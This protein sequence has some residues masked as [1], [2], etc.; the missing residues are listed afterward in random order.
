MQSPAIAELASLARVD[1]PP[2]GT[3]EPGSSSIERMQRQFARATM[4]AQC[5]ISSFDG[6]DTHRDPRADAGCFTLEHR[7]TL[8]WRAILFGDRNAQFLLYR[9]LQLETSG[10]FDKPEEVAA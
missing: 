9:N 3:L 6:H 4:L 1:A 7:L 8:K 2:A 5:L 10:A